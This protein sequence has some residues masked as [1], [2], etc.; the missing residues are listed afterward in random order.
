MDGR[1]VLESG[2]NWDNI[3]WSLP[4]FCKLYNKHGIILKYAITNYIFKKV[5]IPV[6]QGNGGQPQMSSVQWRK[7]VQLSNCEHMRITISNLAG[8]T[9][10]K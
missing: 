2:Q 6:D 5:A 1:K 8:R 7:K 9:S 10:C 4:T 3:Y